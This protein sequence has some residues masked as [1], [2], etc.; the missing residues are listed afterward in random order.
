MAGMAELHLIGTLAQD[1]DGPERLAA[2]LAGMQPDAVALETSRADFE[3]RRAGGAAARA[4]AL[5]AIRHKGATAD[6]LD[7]WGR[8][9]QP[10]R[11]HFEA[12]TATAFAAE[13]GVPLH[14]LEVDGDADRSDGTGREGAGESGDADD[15][16]D[17][18]DAGDAGVAEE[19]DEFRRADGQALASLAAHDWRAAYEAEYARAR[20]DLEAKACLEF[21]V[22]LPE[23]PAYRARD[24]VMARRIG[25][26]LARTSPGS[27]GR[28]PRVAVVCAVTHLYFSEARLTIYSQLYEATTGRYLT[29]STG[30]VRDHPIVLPWT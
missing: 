15:A 21:L 8:R 16:D 18:D 19:A 4:A 2:L 29:D 25:D 17:A 5:D 12:F 13:R 3:R 24:R 1:P 22:P 10:E 6:T 20:I 30:A 9:L 23:Q 7:F 28:P 27:A 26:L 14:F 11:R